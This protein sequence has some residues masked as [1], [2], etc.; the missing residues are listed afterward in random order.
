[1]KRDLLRIADLATEEIDA[2]LALAGRL[3]KAL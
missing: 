2:V 3:K 1:M